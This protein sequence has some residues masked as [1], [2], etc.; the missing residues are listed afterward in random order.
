MRILIVDDEKELAQQIKQALEEQRYTAETASDGEEALNR[1]FD[2]PFDLVVLDI[3][4]PLRD[5]L[6]VLKEMRKA[7]IK[8]PVLMLTARD[9]TVDKISGLD[10][11]ADD[12]LTKPFYTDELMARVRAL[13]RRSGN[14]A[15]S[16]IQS[17]GLRLD[18]VSR[19]VT[20][21]GAPVELT[22]REFSI[23]EFLLYN[24]NRAVSRFSLAE[25][26]WGDDFDPFSMSNY[27][28][29]HM[30]NLR[31]KLGDSAQGSVIRTIRGMGYI[32]RD[33]QE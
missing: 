25:H 18:T 1:L 15:D 29:V 5:G 21:N 22:A 17:G 12:Y 28:D 16:V 19:E 4:L 10:L 33:E 13:F 7:G 31:R 9:S 32:I 14:Q 24:R 23:L 20:L 30:K 26:V 3:M 2:V 11:G 6:S 8:T 27:I